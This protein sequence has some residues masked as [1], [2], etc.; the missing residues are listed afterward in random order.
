MSDKEKKRRLDV[1][2][3]DGF[4]LAGLGALFWGFFQVYPPAAWIVTG[5]ALFFLAVWRSR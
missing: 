4:G 3:R 1:D 2:M 5:A